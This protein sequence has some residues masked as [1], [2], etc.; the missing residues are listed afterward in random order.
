MTKKKKKCKT[1]SES[2]ASLVFSER[3]GHLCPLQ[4]GTQKEVGK[5]VP[6]IGQLFLAA[7]T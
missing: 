1:L 2:R 3:C 5:S 6:Q 7:P 4:L